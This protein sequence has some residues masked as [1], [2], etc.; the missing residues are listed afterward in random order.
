MKLS[1]F[2][3]RTTWVLV[4]AI[5]LIG[6]SMTLFFTYFDKVTTEKNIGLSKE[7]KKNQFFAAKKFLKEYD[8]NFQLLTDFSIFESIDS[9][10]TKLG[11]YDTVFIATSRVGMSEKL[12][13]NMQSWINAGG[14][15]VVVATEPFDLKLGES[16]DKFLDDLGFRYFLNQEYMD[17]SKEEELMHLT[18]ENYEAETELHFD[19]SGYFE[20]NSG[21]ARFIASNA[22]SNLLIQYDYGAGL[23]TVLAD[24]S[25]WDNYYIAQ[26]DHAIFMLQLIGVNKQAWLIYNRNQ[27]SLLDLILNSMPM[28]VISTLVLLLILLGQ[29]LWRK[30]R[31]K[32]DEQAWQ[33]EIMSHI[34]AAGEM[35]YSLDEGLIL[36]EQQREII[37]KRMAHLI[38]GYQRL[39][40]EKQL[41]KLAQHS[42]IDKEKIKELW[43]PDNESQE[44]FFRKIKLAQKIRK[45]L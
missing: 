18:F 33:R 23:V 8:I 6:I 7:A 19:S 40:P 28:V 4:I 20:D 34:Y 25:I 13:N 5:T 2:V 32:N 41:L 39:T 16:R 26:H 38:H 22:H 1:F 27:P 14:H 36:I 42:G 37:I 21:K 3:S 45:T 29:K 35:S 15:L 17:V 12:R 10:A 44:S 11:E 30:G 43:L 9:E 24:F 31:L